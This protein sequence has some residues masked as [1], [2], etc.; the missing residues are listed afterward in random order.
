VKP[1][2]NGLSLF[3]ASNPHANFSIDYSA[4]VIILF[5]LNRFA[6]T[7]MFTLSPF[8]YFLYCLILPLAGYFA[9]VKI[10]GEKGKKKKAGV[11]AMEKALA[12]EELEYE[13]EEHMAGDM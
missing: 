13:A 10:F 3:R 5:N 6:P 1:R 9:I 12:R 7:P 2:C 8:K 11:I 4:V